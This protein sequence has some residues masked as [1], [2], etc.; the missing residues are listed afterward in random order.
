MVRWG[1]P[2]MV[3]VLAASWRRS[4]KVRLLSPSR[5]TSRAKLRVSTG[6]RGRNRGCVRIPL[7]HAFCLCL[8]LFCRD[9]YRQRRPIDLRLVSRKPW[10]VIAVQ[11]ID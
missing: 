4:W 11:I 3:N 10:V 1:T 2:A 8:F 6:G 7:I 5:F 9:L